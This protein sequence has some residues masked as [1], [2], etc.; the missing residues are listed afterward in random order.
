M[1]WLLKIIRLKAGPWPEVHNFSDAA[2]QER[3]EVRGKIMGPLSRRV[4]HE[5]RAASG[6]IVALTTVSMWIGICD[7]TCDGKS[8]LLAGEAV[9]NA[10]ALS[11]VFSFVLVHGVLELARV[12]AWRR[13][14]FLVSPSA[15]V[16]K[17]WAGSRKAWLIGH[18]SCVRLQSHGKTAVERGAL[19]KAIDDMA[20]CGEVGTH[21][22][23]YQDAYVLEILQ[24]DGPQ[25][26]L[27][28][29][30]RRRAKALA[31]ALNVAIHEVR[32]AKEEAPPQP[33]GA[34]PARIEA[35][36]V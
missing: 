28:I 17:R 33:I 4:L 10:L 16:L 14:R 21:A 27:A 34:D 3:I 2:G 12:L 6:I 9:A 7:T 24:A 13:V 26:V 19:F 11:A 18:A 15:L 1:R 25:P 35:G 23:F 32:R 36:L 29:T 5:A 8:G 30:G 31:D 20:E 22:L